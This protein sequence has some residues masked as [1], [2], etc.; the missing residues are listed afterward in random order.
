MP[1]QMYWQNFGKTKTDFFTMSGLK[2][3]SKK[4]E[5]AQKNKDKGQ[6]MDGK[7]VK[8]IPRYIPRQMPRHCL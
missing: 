2:L 8:T 3:K 6:L 5:Q 7:N 1:R 4:D